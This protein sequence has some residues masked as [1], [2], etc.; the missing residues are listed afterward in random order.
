MLRCLDH[1]TTETYISYSKWK[2]MKLLRFNVQLKADLI[3][4]VYDTN[5]TSKLERQKSKQ[6]T[7][8]LIKS[9][10][11]PKIR[12]ISPKW[13]WRLRWEGF[14]SEVKVQWFNLRSKT[15]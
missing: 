15:D 12:Q 6:K 10:N 4:L 2:E 5:E 13:W 8:E 9:C 7:D 11:G 14:E 3:S 1:G